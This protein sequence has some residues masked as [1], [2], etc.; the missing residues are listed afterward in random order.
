MGMA[1]VDFRVVRREITAAARRAFTLIRSKHPDER[2]YTFA[3]CSDDEAESLCASANTE[4]GYARG[5]KR[6]E[7][8]PLGNEAGVRWHCPEWAY[9]G[10]EMGEFRALDPLIEI[11]E[12]IQDDPGPFDAFRARLYASMIL[13]LKD[14][15]AE[16]FFGTGQDR[17]RV[18][19]FCD[20]AST[21]DTYWYVVE[22]ARALNPPSTFRAFLP[23]W[24]DFVGDEGRAIIR[25]PE[26]FSPLSQQVRA[27]LA[28]EAGA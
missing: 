17:E 7:G 11:D 26:S 20:L 3:L 23:Q 14:L 24:L 22:S 1:S 21:H 2:F 25:D 19:L 9:H 27:I 13:G 15:D 5:L 8:R 6:Y 28:G 16:G 12:E 18:A 4:E 10:D